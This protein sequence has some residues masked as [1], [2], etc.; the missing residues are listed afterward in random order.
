MVLGGLGSFREPLVYW[1]L[2][3][4]AQV[5]NEDLKRPKGCWS[6]GI[7]F[8]GSHLGFEGLSGNGCLARAYMRRFVSRS[9]WF[10]KIS[11][12]LDDVPLIHGYRAQCLRLVVQL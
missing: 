10:F 7:C 4:L 5:R 1:A 11:R 2:L 8:Y 9:W 3:G 12:L 6:F